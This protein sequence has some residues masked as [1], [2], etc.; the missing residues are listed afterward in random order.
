M[1]FEPMKKFPATPIEIIANKGEA[2]FHRSLNLVRARANE[3]TAEIR[4]HHR[5]PQ[6]LAAENG[7]YAYRIRAQ[8]PNQ[9]NNNPT[10]QNAITSSMDARFSSNR[11]TSVRLNGF[12]MNRRN[13][14]RRDGSL[15]VLAYLA[16]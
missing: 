16:A 6:R 15:P 3:I 11:S 12:D 13:E 4:A 9:Q 7:E 14:S 5:A 10:N 1:P 8:P 2:I